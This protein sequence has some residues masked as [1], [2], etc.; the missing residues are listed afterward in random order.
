MFDSEQEFIDYEFESMVKSTLSDTWFENMN[1]VPDE[2]EVVQ[3]PAFFVIFKKTI[4]NFM[5][6]INEEDDNGKWII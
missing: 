3:L 5:D 2:Q 6:D 1:A 4:Q